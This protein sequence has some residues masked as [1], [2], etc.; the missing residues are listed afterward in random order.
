M[1]LIRN[2]ILF[3]IIFSFIYIKPSLS[4]TQTNECVFLLHDLARTKSSMEKLANRIQKDGYNIINIGYHSRRKIVFFLK[5]GNF[6]HPLNATKKIKNLGNPFQNQPTF[7]PPKRPSRNC[8]APNVM[9]T[10]VPLKLPILAL[11]V[12]PSRG[13]T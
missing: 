12:W 4:Y 11:N 13:H 1:N 3:L 2:T 6:D 8:G 5:N 7:R 9:M 10:S